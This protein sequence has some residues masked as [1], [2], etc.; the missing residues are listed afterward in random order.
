MFGFSKVFLS[1]RVDGQCG[2]LQK[3]KKHPIEMSDV[4]VSEKSWRVTA[5]DHDDIQSHDDDFARVCA[6]QMSSINVK[7]LPL[8]RTQGVSLT[9]FIPRYFFLPAIMI[10]YYNIISISKIAIFQVT[11]H[12]AYVGKRS[13]LF[14]SS[15]AVKIIIST[16]LQRVFFL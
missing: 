4:Q 11:C 13:F 10:D 1:T 5:A 6:S 8:K 3:K 7:R 16:C 9:R 12:T 14:Y 2:F 15:S